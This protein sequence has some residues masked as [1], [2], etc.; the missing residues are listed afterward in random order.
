MWFHEAFLIWEANGP[1]RGF[2]DALLERGYRNIFYRKQEQR[3]GGGKTSE[4]PGWWAS[5]ELNRQL[6]EEYARD[7]LQ[8]KVINRSEDAIRECAKYQFQKDGTIAHSGSRSAV[9]PSGAR[10]NHGDQVTADALMNHGF[11][12]FGATVEEREESTEPEFE[13][14][15]FIGRRKARE[16]KA[17]L[18][19]VW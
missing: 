14:H 4:F 15:S 8:G 10:S 5:G 18:S 11:K 13:E 1:G 9:D 17:A 3:L 19:S 2:G 12:E 7:L 16:K 6:L